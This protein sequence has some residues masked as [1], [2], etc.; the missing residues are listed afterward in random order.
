LERI[1][2]R[3]DSADPPRQNR[4]I[5][6][7]RMRDNSPAVRPQDVKVPQEAMLLL[8]RDTAERFHV[9]P[10]AVT[11]LRNGVK[12]LSIA[13][14][15][16]A[17]L[18]MLDQLQ[19]L[20]GCRI[21]PVQANEQDILRAI[22]AHYTSSYT[23]APMDLVKEY[24]GTLETPSV[25]TSE[26]VVGPQTEQRGAST[27]VE[28][29]MQRAITDR[30]SDIHL[31]PHQKSVLVRNRIDGIMYDQTAYE[32]AIH[33][34][35]ISRIKIL[36]NLDIAQTRL[37]QDG[38]FDVTFGKQE[39]DVRVSIV[40]SA[41]GEK[42]VLRLLPKNATMLDFVQLGIDGRNSVTLEDMLT[43]PFGMILATGPTG[44]GKTT[45]LY[46]C[47]TKIDC[48]TKNVITAE[49]PIEYQFPR[50][51]QM[52]VHP[53]IGLT[54]A[55][56]LRAIL[57][58]DPDI[59][60]VGEIRD[61]ETLEIAVQA[62]LTGHL[63]LSTLHCNDAAAGA[64]RM[65][66]MGAEPFLIAS[67]LNCLTAQRLVRKVCEHCREPE[68]VSDQMRERLNLP[69]D[70][71]VYYR[72]R[73]CTHCRNTGFLGR[74]SVFEVVPIHSDIEHAIV[75]KMPAGEIRAIISS[76]GFLT[77]LDDGIA[78]ARTGVTSLDEVI[79]AVFTTVM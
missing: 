52:Q 34:Q 50:I 73:G 55:A 39:Y 23:D 78:K 75:R 22:E 16:P 60:M 53:K 14:A 63:V 64:A 41:F 5:E 35:V 20:C 74:I 61:L 38:R 59:I 43:R 30:A 36:S 67:S 25:V 42:A 79:R 45:T 15:D 26:T 19:Q 68:T 66:D 28:N 56:G 9:C 4:L 6:E 11:E 29:I 71:T 2:V 49:D 46:S 69:N 12:A 17:N 31:E 3:L 24:G 48:V 10:L 1:R 70:N 76:L 65:V 62:A 32:L 37:P 58:Q 57:R 33:T 44:S 40:P 77:L 7:D 54:F 18:M 47:L 51:T 72:G 21:N 8:T 27:T 13:T